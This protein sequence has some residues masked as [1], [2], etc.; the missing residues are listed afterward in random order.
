MFDYI[1]LAPRFARE[2]LNAYE[3][4]NG[5]DGVPMKLQELMMVLQIELSHQYN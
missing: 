2:V 3:N 1:K 4:W 5:R